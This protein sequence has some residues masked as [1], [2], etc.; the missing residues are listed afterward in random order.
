MLARALSGRVSP[1]ALAVIVEASLGQDGWRGMFGHPEYHFDD[2]AIP[3]GLAY[4]EACRAAA[5]RAD[6]PAEAW[7][8]LGRLT[9]AAQDFY[10]HSNYVTLWKERLDGQPLPAPEAI[11]GLDPDL[12]RHPRLRTARVYL[13]L[14]V[15]YFVPGLGPLVKLFLPRDSHAWMN[16]DHPRTGP[17]FPYAIEAAV[18]RTVFEFERTLAAIGEERGEAAVRAFVDEARMPPAG[19]AA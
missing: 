1:R 16:L 15:L 14:D 7:E 2:N 10:A 13:P 18:Q 4:I 19:S 9:H 3:Q 12:L 6:S 5:A 11:D 8:A 17:L